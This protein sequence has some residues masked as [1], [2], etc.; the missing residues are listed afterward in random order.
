VDSRTKLDAW[1]AKY[2]DQ[3]PTH[4]PQCIVT[5][6]EF[7]KD[8]KHGAPERIRLYHNTGTAIFEATAATLDGVTVRVKGRPFKRPE[9]VSDDLMAKRLNVE[10]KDYLLDLRPLEERESA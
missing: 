1:R 4:G 2:H 7:G 8:H 10:A 9:V 5:I 6:V 3:V